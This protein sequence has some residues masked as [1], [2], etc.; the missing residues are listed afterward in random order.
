MLALIIIIISFLLDGILSNFLPF[1]VNDLSLF[2]PLLTLTSLIIIYPLYRK[3]EKQ[4]FL[5]LFITG[6]LFDLFYTNLFLL[7]ALIYL[8]IGFILKI[9]YKNTGFNYF[10]LLFIIPLLIIS[11]ELLTALIILIFNLVPLTIPKLLYKISHSL[12]LNM[13]YAEI[14]YLIINILPQKYKK[15]SLN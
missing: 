4:Y 10:K 2:T 1:M 13:I 14:I 5:T 8:A 3:K 12:L 11:Y 9:I 6:I 15:I 7:N